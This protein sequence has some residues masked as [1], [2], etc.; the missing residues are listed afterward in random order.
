M[1]WRK[2]FEYLRQDHCP[3]C[4]DTSRVAANRNVWNT[5]ELA[6]QDRLNK[7]NTQ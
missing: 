5:P 3:S 4:Q 2:L 1:N 6:Q 7:E